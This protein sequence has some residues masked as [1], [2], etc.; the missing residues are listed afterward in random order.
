[1]EGRVAVEESE[2]VDAKGIEVKELLM[3]MDVGFR[4]ED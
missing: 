2:E 1:M 4:R 3:V